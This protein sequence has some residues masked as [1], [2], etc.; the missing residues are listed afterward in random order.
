MVH[1][2]IGLVSKKNNSNHFLSSSSHYHYI[3]EQKFIRWL[4][5]RELAIDKVDAYLYLQKLINN[6]V[7]QPSFFFRCNNTYFINEQKIPTDGMEYDVSTSFPFRTEN[8][9]LVI[10]KSTWQKY[11]PNHKSR[12]KLQKEIQKA[13]HELKKE[14]GRKHIVKNA[15][16]RIEMRL[17]ENA[18]TFDDYRNLKTL[19][20]RIKDVIE[21]EQITL[22][23]HG[24]HIEF[25][26]SSELSDQLSSFPYCKKLI[27]LNNGKN[28]SDHFKHVLINETHDNYLQETRRKLEQYR[29]QSNC[30]QD[31]IDLIQKY[32]DHGMPFEKAKI[33]ALN[34]TRNK[35][36]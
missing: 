31:K 13:L 34:L 1:P 14:F 17:Y 24:K 8:G 23:A 28:D 4:I 27:V 5:K 21:E 16:K 22:N 35:F 9:T 25:V 2:E 19:K 11:L 32:I 30:T 26:H 6:D 7:L 33:N 12:R 18:A 3:T 29:Q 36:L 20:T 10:R 15:A